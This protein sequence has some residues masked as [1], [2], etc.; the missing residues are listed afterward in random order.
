MTESVG[1]EFLGGL[2]VK[3]PGFY[4]LGPGRI[5]DGEMR[6]HKLHFVAKKK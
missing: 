4:Y 2:V 1:Q 3:F 6:S 5:P